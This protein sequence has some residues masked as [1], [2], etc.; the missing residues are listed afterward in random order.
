MAPRALR[1]MARVLGVGPLHPAEDV[2]PRLGSEAVTWGAGAPALPADPPLGL[3]DLTNPQKS[4]R[5]P[6]T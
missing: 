1:P 4:P 2:E 6:R 3:S 5:H